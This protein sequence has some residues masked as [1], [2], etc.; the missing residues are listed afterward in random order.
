MRVSSLGHPHCG[1]KLLWD[2][3]GS[4]A[5]ICL[6]GLSW[7]CPNASESFSFR[8]KPAQSKLGSG[9]NRMSWECTFKEHGL[10]H[11]NE[12]KVANGFPFLCTHGPTMGQTD[13]LPGVQQGTHDLGVLSPASR[14]CACWIGWGGHEGDESLVCSMTAP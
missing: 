1:T 5:V 7:I 2:S 14:G 11:P 10:W 12:A 13:Q 3:V 4:K 9:D 8:N 6:L